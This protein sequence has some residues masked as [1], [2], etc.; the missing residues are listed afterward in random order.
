MD[1]QVLRECMEDIFSKVL[2]NEGEN[3]LEEPM[4]ENAHGHEI[5]RP[6][7]DWLLKILNNNITESKSYHAHSFV[8]EFFKK[9]SKEEQD[10]DI[11]LE[12]TWWAPLL[13]T[14]M[15]RKA[16]SN[17][18]PIPRWQ[19]AG[20]DLVV[21]NNKDFL[22]EYNDIVL[23]NVKGHNIKR[24]SRHPNIM[25][26]QRLLVFFRWILTK[27]QSYLEKCNLWFIGLSYSIEENIAKVE[28]IDI[29]DLFLL[30]LNS[31]PQI[32]FDAAM[33]IQWH[34]H[35]MIEKK[36]TKLEFIDSLTNSFLSEWIKTRDRKNE[37]FE[38]LAHEIK[39][40][41]KERS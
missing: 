18:Q 8:E 6:L 23:L 3:I 19:H 34:V 37:K 32:N 39:E 11:F 9:V 41:L 5:G 22:K 35:S 13:V 36:Q 10:I 27:P 1:S 24:K 28:T 20:S 25:S 38:K 12:R 26:G 17:N 14:R 15:H 33:Q 4:S 31:L 40:L 30:D 21:L 2:G 29:R 7:E 16:F